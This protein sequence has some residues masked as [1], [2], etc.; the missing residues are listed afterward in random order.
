MWPRLASVAAAFMPAGPPPTTSHERRSR[1]GLR[2]GRNTDSRPA[3]GFTVQWIGRRAH[4]VREA[5]LVG[6][7]AV[8]DLLLATGAHLLDPRGLGELLAREGHDVRLAGGEDR[9]DLLRAADPAD[10][11]H[12]RAVDGRAERPAGLGEPAVGRAATGG[13]LSEN[14]W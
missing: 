13:T 5:T 4:E 1:A 7:D 2:Y 3:S 12:R 14:A 11:E 10:E 6:A 8:R 9:V